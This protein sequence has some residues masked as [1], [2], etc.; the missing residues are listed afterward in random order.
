MNLLPEKWNVNPQHFW[1]RGE[2][3][4]EPVSFD[5]DLGLWNVYGYPEAVEILGD[6]KS[7]SSNTT[8]LLPTEVDESLNDGVLFQ[9]DPPQHRKLR[10]L[11]SHAFSPKTVA[12]LEPRI[13]RLAHE[14]LDKAAERDRLELVSDLAYPLPVIVI[15]ELLGI[16]GSD[17]DL[18]KAWVDRLFESTGQFSLVNHDEDQERALQTQLDVTKDMTDYLRGHVTERRQEPREDLLTGLV[19]AEVDGERLTDQQIVTFAN[20]LLVAGH[21]TTTMLLGN[22]VLCLDAHPEAFAEVR[23]NRSALPG[24]IE[25]SLRFFTP[26]TAAARATATEVEIAGVRVPADQMLM[27]WVAAANRDGRQFADPDVF[28][29]SRDPNPHLGFGRGMHFCLGASL[30]RVEA[31]IA[32]NVLLDRFPTLHTAPEEPPAFVVSP[33]MSGVHTLPL[34]TG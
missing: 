23:A 4:D 32:L 28:D 5:P 12:N 6:F 17:R 3:P 15:A 8:R 21:I 13:N 14:L 11:V 30:A 24:V 18:F 19:Q 34:L 2:H 20:I 29:P 27:V 7:F 16:P 9:M 10:K 31:R 22:T 25:E 33:E 1:L 26:F